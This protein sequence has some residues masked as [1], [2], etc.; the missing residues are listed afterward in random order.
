MLAP[1]TKEN[2]SNSPSSFAV[3][4]TIAR[5]TNGSRTASPVQRR[6]RLGSR[7]RRPA[8]LHSLSNIAV[9]NKKTFL[10]RLFFVFATSGSS[11]VRLK[12]ASDY[13]RG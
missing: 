13:F 3:V 2:P 4:E 11:S 7:N 1:R 9:P 12:E 10:S 8:A 6:D 5:Q